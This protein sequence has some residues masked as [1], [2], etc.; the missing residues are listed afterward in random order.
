MAVVNATGMV[1]MKVGMDA[2]VIKKRTFLPQK[3][4]HGLRFFA[5]FRPIL[6]QVSAVFFTL[7]A[8]LVIGIAVFRWFSTDKI[9]AAADGQAAQVVEAAYRQLGV[10]GADKWARW[11]LTRLDDFRYRATIGVNPVYVAMDGTIIGDA[12]KFSEYRRLYPSVQAVRQMPPL[13]TIK[14]WQKKVAAILK[15]E[16]GHGVDIDVVI[17]PLGG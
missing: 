4:L 2:E 8:W 11:N 15:A 14:I 17:V 9:A 1:R 10:Y 7:F 12:A 16:L 5:A 3:V 6:P 13:P